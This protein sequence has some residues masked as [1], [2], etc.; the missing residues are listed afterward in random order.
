MWRRCLGSVKPRIYQV[1]N[2]SN[3]Y[4]NSG[5]DLG[6][7][8]HK[9][10]FVCWRWWKHDLCVGTNAFM[11]PIKIDATKNILMIIILPS[12]I[13]LLHNV[14]KRP[15]GISISERLYLFS[16]TPSGAP[17]GSPALTYKWTTQLLKEIAP[18][19]PLDLSEGHGGG[20]GVVGDE[21]HWEVQQI[22]HGTSWPSPVN[23]LN[24]WRPLVIHIYTL[25]THFISKTINGIISTPF[26]LW[27][28]SFDLI[29]VI[30]GTVDKYTIWSR[31]MAY[32][33]HI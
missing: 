21:Q 11:F 31:T 28:H 17:N 1:I 32:L 27:F 12:R 16:R 7:L 29:P 19:W 24:C 26:G 25:S 10:C 8:T 9:I 3:T 6:F 33:N 30:R 20:P 5:H 15:F 18:P 23:H 4:I 22:T 13:W 14:A 2:K